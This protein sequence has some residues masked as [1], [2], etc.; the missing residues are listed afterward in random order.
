VIRSDASEAHRLSLSARVLSAE[1]RQVKRNNKVRS[2]SAACGIG[3]L[4]AP[5]RRPQARAQPCQSRV[6]SGILPGHYLAFSHP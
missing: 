1:N 2:A 4:P 6:K 3:I 5:V